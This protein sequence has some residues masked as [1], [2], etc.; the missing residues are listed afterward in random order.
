MVENA[1]SRRELLTRLPVVAG[2]AWHDS[3]PSVDKIRNM[4]IRTT[5]ASWALF[6]VDKPST[7]GLETISVGHPD[8]LL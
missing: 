2:L 6:V 3:L 4:V 8:V 7:G 5:H 1:I